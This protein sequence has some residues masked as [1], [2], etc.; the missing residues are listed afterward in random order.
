MNKKAFKYDSHREYLAYRLRNREWLNNPLELTLM[1]VPLCYIMY[2]VTVQYPGKR[3][4]DGTQEW[5]VIIEP[6]PF[7]HTF[8][9]SG[10]KFYK[11]SLILKLKLFELSILANAWNKL[12][13]QG[14]ILY[15]HFLTFQ[16]LL[17]KWLRLLFPVIDIKSWSQDS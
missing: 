15:L 7:F 12:N 17:L 11:W 16:V 8:S 1:Y 9:L 4:S 2:Y 13:K 5:I 10:K 14:L 6:T 3:E